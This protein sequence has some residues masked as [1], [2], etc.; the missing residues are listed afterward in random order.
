MSSESP[1]FT[2]VRRALTDA[3]WS[4]SYPTFLALAT[5][6]AKLAGIPL[7]DLLRITRANLGR[8]PHLCIGRPSK[9]ELTKL[10]G[11]LSRPDPA[12]VQSTP[13]NPTPS[14]PSHLPGFPWLPIKRPA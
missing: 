2:T 8:L 12:P 10:I 6:A 5:D 4:R 11:D 1:V 13:A 14:L 3:E 7:V 9:A